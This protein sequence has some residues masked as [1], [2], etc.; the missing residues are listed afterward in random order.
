M[1]I[2]YSKEL[3][4]AIEAIKNGVPIVLVDEEDREFEGDLVL[5]AEKVNFFNL[6][7]LF[8]HGR[9][10]MCLPCTS[11]KLEQFDIPMQHS[12]N[13]DQFATPFA[14]GIDA[15]K[16]ITTGMSLDDRLET[17]KTFVSSEGKPDDLSQPGHLFPLKAAKDLLKERQG[18]TEGTI[19]LMNLANV[20]PVGIIIEMMDWQGQ[21]V[22]GEGLEKFAKLYNLPF[23]SIEQI[24]NEVYN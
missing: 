21:M 16:N 18:H 15:S 13:K 12:N 24:K 6:Q 11:D 1:S 22:K 2:K 17:I 10:L 14:T 4:D 8:L 20:E 5:S 3:D 7:F 19:E 23:I 9:G